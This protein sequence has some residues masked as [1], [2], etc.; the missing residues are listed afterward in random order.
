MGDEDLV[1]LDLSG[2]QVY[3]L[4]VKKA[5]LISPCSKYRYSLSRIW[6]EALPPLLCIGLN[7]STADAELDDPTIRREVAFSRSNGFGGLLKGNLFAFRSTDPAG[8]MAAEDPVGPDNDL[9]LIGM[10]TQAT[11]ILAAWGTR[12]SFKGRDKA[13]SELL[14]G[15]KLMCLGRTKEGHPRHPLYVKADV[16]FQEWG[17]V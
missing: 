15:R 2:K 17:A 1:A 16:V 12:G 9:A 10:M 6:D 7:P 5:A 14:K 8:M 4:R 11:C 13:V 3:T